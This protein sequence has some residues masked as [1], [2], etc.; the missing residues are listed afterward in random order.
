M[1]RS[2]MSI[3]AISHAL[4]LHGFV[5]IDRA[6]PILFAFNALN[7]T[8][9]FYAKTK[10]NYVEFSMYVDNVGTSFLKAKKKLVD[11]LEFA[12]TRS[13]LFIEERKGIH[14]TSV[15]LL[16]RKAPSLIA[17]PSEGGILTKTISIRELARVAIRAPYI[18]EIDTTL[19]NE[20][21]SKE[22]PV[23]ERTFVDSSLISYELDYK[24]NAFPKLPL[25]TALTK[26]TEIN[27]DS[28]STVVTK[29]IDKSFTVILQ[30]HHV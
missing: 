19:L 25:Y 17:T 6:L 8:G 16:L 1:V 27:N 5:D 20:I 10:G 3:A 23:K 12:N 11:A 30:R 21:L 14:P 7:P 24:P 9:K 4:Q 18:P 22:A 28:L 26:Y 29:N 2:N 13:G 15:I